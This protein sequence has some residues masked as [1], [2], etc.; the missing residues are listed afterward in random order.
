MRGF[1]PTKNINRC[2][3]ILNWFP[4]KPQIP[5]PALPSS[6]G[7]NPTYS[8]RSTRGLK[9]I[10]TRQQ[11]I[12][13][14][15]FKLESKSWLEILDV[16]KYSSWCGHNC[17]YCQY[18]VVMETPKTLTTITLMI[19]LQLCHN[20]VT[21]H[22]LKPIFNCKLICEILK[23][24]FNMHTWTIKRVAVNIH[25]LQGMTHLPP[26]QSWCSLNCECSNS[27]SSLEDLK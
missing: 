7:W 4:K 24:S 16:M 11:L 25:T 5:K 26:I 20:N 15:G 8:Q 2:L 27:S 1:I 13:T 22:F 17:D 9:S 14:K 3:H 19:W 23:E 18:G 10:I 21:N 6:R 12:L